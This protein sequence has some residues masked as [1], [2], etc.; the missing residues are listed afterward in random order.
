M[1][2]HNNK[3]LAAA[4]TGLIESSGYKKGYI[5]D[6]LGIANQNFKKT[7]NKQNMSLD[8]ANK[9]LNIIGYE[10]KISIQKI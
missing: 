10:A 2:I 1:D 6:V 5:A 4:I 7:V 3:E 9:I 8:D